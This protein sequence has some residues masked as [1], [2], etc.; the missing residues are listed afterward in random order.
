MSI[1]FKENIVKLDFTFKQC[2]KNVESGV[3]LTENFEELDKNIA[4]PEVLFALE[5]AKRF[6]ANAVYF[7][8]FEDGRGAIP[9]IYI[10]DNTSDRLTQKRRE[11]H[12]K[13]W[14]GSQVPIYI[15]IG[16]SNAEV[17]DARE[18]IKE[19]E[20]NEA[21]ETIALFGNAIK[22][23]SALGFDDGL[24][25]EEEN[26][27]GRFQYKKSVYRDLI[28]GL[29]NIYNEFQQDSGLD[30]HIAL[31]LL[32]QCLLVKYLEEREGGKYFIEK[33]FRK[34]YNCND[35]CEVIR[36]GKL[37][38]LFD[39]L[40]IDFNGRIFELDDKSKAEIQKKLKNK[41]AQHLAEYLDAKIQNQ[42]YVLWRLYSFS[43]LPV[44]L[45]SSVYEELLTNS[46]TASKDIVYTPEMI[47]STL[48][49]ECMPLRQP[50]KDFKVIDV[51]CGS[52]IFLVKAYKRMIQ[53]W[54]YERWKTSKQLEKP[55]LRELKDLLLKNING[56]DI[57]KDAIRLTVFSLAL[58]ML[59]EVDL[60]PPL[61]EKLK[62]PDL[63][64][65]NIKEENFFKFI[66]NDPPNDFDL[67]IG[68][69]PFNLQS[70]N[71]KERRT[72]YFKNIE[73]DFGYKNEIK[74]PDENPALHFLTKAMQL[75]K[76]DALLCLIQPSGPLLYQEDVE[77][78]Q[79]V[80]SKY[81]LLQVID[82]T[83]LANVLWGKKNVATAAIFLQNS[84]PDEN[85]VVH[86]V[87]KRTFANVNRL[88]LEFDHYDFHNVSKGN[89][90]N[91]PFI[92]KANLLGGGRINSIIERISGIKT[93]EQFLLDKKDEGWIAREGF[94]EGKE[95][96]PAKYITGKNF[97]PTKALDENGIDFT[98]IT[99]CKITKF[100]TP[101]VEEIFTPPH[102]L[103]KGNIGKEKLIVAFSKDYLVFRAKIIGIH[104]DQ[105]KS[106]KDFYN[107]LESNSDVLRFYI[108]CTS[109]QFLITRATALIKDDLMIIPYSENSPKL[110]LS[111]AEQICVRD[112]LKFIIPNDTSALMQSSKDN[113][114]KEFSSVFSK[115]LNS[116]YKTEDKSF[117]LSKIIDAGKYYVTQFLYSSNKCEV[118]IEKK[119]SLEESIKYLVPIKKE[120]WKSYHIQRVLKIY[121]KDSIILAKPKQLR[122]WLPSIALRDAD[123]AFAGYIKAR[124]S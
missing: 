41:E 97:L 58:A 31:K 6:D 13:I 14:S 75:L 16:K 66:T 5:T 46:D 79:A 3:F 68:N 49:D 101:S 54:R 107:Y 50:Q 44:E 106:L 17:F 28:T 67:V 122:Y 72:E 32:V 70:V 114:I 59:D 69:P 21:I 89:V 10:Y 91:Y 55:S 118:K 121:G 26:N 62:F 52:G 47:V 8:F 56:V 71:G 78:K 116:I 115:S 88:F 85:D 53:W 90:I 20:E 43:H 57:N 92:W 2:D 73:N 95:G 7:R 119:V 123:E 124:Y 35:F 99:K 104:S 64:E 117:Q 82:F 9:Q 29:K 1:L 76:K 96:N 74:I 51:S 65:D 105:E 19:D 102:I 36:A 60:D 33:Y 80:F 48:V 27:K 23:F 30:K 11:I 83:K 120:N 18:R 38:E 87:A 37:L 109:G 40:S 113:D 12:K 45:I 25:W 4:T 86:I 100:D 24:F 63:V 112:V 110:K 22:K 111:E 61:W 34:K 94:I 93:F 15:I 84:E 39:Q 108:A 98:K 81:N 42:S 77:F 103:I